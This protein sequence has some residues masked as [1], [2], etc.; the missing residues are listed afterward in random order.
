MILGSDFN[1]IT[2]EAFEL[3][4]IW[5]RTCN[6]WKVC[7][8]GVRAYVNMERRY[9][10]YYCVTLESQLY[11][12]LTRAPGTQY[13]CHVDHWH[14]TVI[15]EAFTADRCSENQGLVLFEKLEFSYLR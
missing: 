3:R 6:L 15:K 4:R 9:L 14:F 10:N 1:I 7:H 5:L 8:D 12:H 11:Y 13:H 2:G